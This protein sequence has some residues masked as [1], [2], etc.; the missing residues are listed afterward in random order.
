MAPSVPF[1]ELPVQAFVVGTALGMTAALI[2][3]LRTGNLERW[4][5][6]IACVAVPLFYVTLLFSVLLELT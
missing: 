5:L 3:Y 1:L 6:V 4:P 2:N